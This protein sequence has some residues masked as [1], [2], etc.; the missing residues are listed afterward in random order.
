MREKGAGNNHGIGRKPSSKASFATTIASSSL[1]RSRYRIKKVSAASILLMAATTATASS[2]S[3]LAENNNSGN[4]REGLTDL[5]FK[6]AIKQCGKTN[7]VDGMCVD[8]PKY[9]AMPDWD[10]SKVTDM[11]NAFAQTTSGKGQ[12]KFTEFQGLIG[13]WDTSSVTSMRNMFE[14][15]RDFTGD[16]IEHWNTEKVE[17][18]SGMF[19]NAKAF[20]ANVSSWKGKATEQPQKDV[21]RGAEA[22]VVTF[23]CEH[24][25]QG[26]IMKTCI[27][28]IV[29]EDLSSNSRKEAMSAASLGD[30]AEKKKL[31]DETFKNAIEECLEEYPI[32][33]MCKG[34]EYGIMPDW[35]V[36]QV[37][38]MSRAFYDK[39][40][41]NGDLSKWDVS[42]VKN[43]QEMFYGADAFDADI[44]NWNVKNLENAQDMFHD[45]KTFNRPINRWNTAKVINMSGMFMGAKK[46]NSDISNWNVEKVKAMRN[47]F[48]DASSFDQPIG[49]W[50]VK[51]CEDMRFM[52]SE[53]KMFK[54]KIQNWKGPAAKEA[55]FKMFSEA[56]GFLGKFRCDEQ[57]HGPPQSCR[58]R[59]IYNALAALGESDSA[60]R[61]ALGE[62]DV[63]LASAMM[64]KHSPLAESIAL[65]AF[66]CI[67]IAFVTVHYRE[68]SSQN[69]KKLG[70]VKYDEESTRLLQ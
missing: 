3:V 34:S 9:G 4:E 42:Q 1:A 67:A 57:E 61:A 48:S 39:W 44:S 66:I 21:F 63:H 55:Q 10:T 43:T 35:D 47:M 54:Q 69:K 50:N 40:D 64:F 13:T 30:K 24:D 65:V 25:E 46:F 53:A 33:G 19:R 2:S 7:P 12:P 22:F 32:G 26:A 8:L 17:D 41:F 60:F 52:F 59:A 18:M 38:D 5:T 45:A 28:P 37:T 56:Y 51:S 62:S 70:A 68:F 15:C 14:G 23:A 6:N 29:E 11:S 36:S 49:K 20:K 27:K 58:P 31:T 16:G